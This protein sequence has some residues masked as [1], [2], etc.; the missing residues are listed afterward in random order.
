MSS[1]EFSAELLPDARLRNVVMISGASAALAGFVLIMQMPLHA[2]MGS[3]LAIAWTVHCGFELHGR[4]RMELRVARIAINTRGEIRVTDA[5]G[6][7]VLVELLAGTVVMPNLAWLRMRF[8]ADGQQ[9]AEL[10]RGNALKDVQW[11]RFQLIWQQR[12]QTFSSPE[13]S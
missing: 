10:L 11:H 7:T 9:Y 4:W 5:A 6:R 8:V 12:R 2:V 13:R 3:I 1:N